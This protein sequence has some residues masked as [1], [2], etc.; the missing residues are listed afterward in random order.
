VEAVLNGQTVFSDVAHLPFSGP[1]R[2][3]ARVENIP[4]GAQVTVTEVYSGAVYTAQANTQTTAVG[5]DGR[6]SVDFTNNY[7]SSNKG[8]GTVVNQFDYSTENGWRWTQAA[9]GE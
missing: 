6:A 5:A 9:D 3:T 8:G 1:G 2:Q 7:D 4:M